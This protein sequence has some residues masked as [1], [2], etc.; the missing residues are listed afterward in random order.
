[1]DLIQAGPKR[2]EVEFDQPDVDIL[3]LRLV[4]PRTDNHSSF[5]KRYRVVRHHG[6]HWTS[7][8]KLWLRDRGAAPG[9]RIEVYRHASEPSLILQLKRSE[10]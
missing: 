3:V 1:M 4:T 2:A 9:D 7:I 10:G 8:P 5:N 6:T